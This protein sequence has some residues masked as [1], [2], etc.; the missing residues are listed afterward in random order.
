MLLL[1]RLD[2]RKNKTEEQD[3]IAQ[4]QTTLLTDY[5]TEEQENATQL[6]TTLRTDNKKEE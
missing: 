1:K 6:Q 2:T 5:K 3:N 4:L